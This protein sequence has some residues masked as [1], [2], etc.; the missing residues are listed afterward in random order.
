MKI[1]MIGTGKI[2][3]SLGPL[4]AASGHEVKFGSRDPARIRGEVAKFGHGASAGTYREAAQFGDAVFLAVPWHALAET[5][6]AAGSLSGKV[7]VDCTNPLTKDMNLAVGCTTSAAEET[8]RACPDAG[9]V[10]A[11]N[12][13][14]AGIYKAGDL[15]SGEQ[16]LDMLYCGDDPAAKRTVAG[17]IESLGLVPVDAGPLSAARLIEPHAVLMIRL[18]FVQGMGAGIAWKLVGGRSGPNSASRGA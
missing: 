18:A 8:A 16:R 11:F 17:I 6:K 15:G 13:I 14:F 9:V 1:G 12:T 10:K 2:G 4:L 7:V 5:L 3:F